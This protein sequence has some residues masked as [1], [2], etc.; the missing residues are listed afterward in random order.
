MLCQGQRYLSNIM[1]AP[2]VSNF[3]ELPQDILETNLEQYCEGGLFT[4]FYKG[5]TSGGIESSFEKKLSK[6]FSFAETPRIPGAQIKAPMF[7]DQ[8]GNLSPSITDPFTHI[9]KPAGV[10]GFEQLPLVE[11]LAHRVQI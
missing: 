6:I 2:K 4:G 1:I 7:L 8:A 3:K 5:P 11:W 10:E 9:L